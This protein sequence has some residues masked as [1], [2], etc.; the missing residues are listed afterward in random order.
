[1][2]ELNDKDRRRPGSEASKQVPLSSVF[3][4]LYGLKTPSDSTFI[5]LRVFGSDSLDRNL[6]GQIGI[7]VLPPTLQTLSSLFARLPIVARDDPST[8]GVQIKPV[9]GPEAREERVRRAGV[10]GV[11]DPQGRCF[12]VSEIGSAGLPGS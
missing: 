11:P 6:F 2:Q 8:P 4:V 5:G 12:A 10:A 9:E 7:T 3:A 1:M